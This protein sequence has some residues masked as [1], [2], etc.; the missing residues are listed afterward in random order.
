MSYLINT[1]LLNTFYL[2]SRLSQTCIMATLEKKLQDKIDTLIAEGNKEWD[3]D[4]NTYFKIMQEAWSYYPQP[5]NNWNESYLLAEELFEAYLI[6]NDLNEA[7]KWLNEM[8]SHNNN[9][10]LMDFDL[11]FNIGKYHFE[12]GEYQKAHNEWA[13]LVRQRGYRYFEGEDPKYLDFY[14]NPER[15]I[16]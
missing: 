16:K 10:H 3:V 15:Y 6:E 2:D 14:R 5:K 1:L 7:K 8:I 13:N 12:N 9:L 11:L 4:R